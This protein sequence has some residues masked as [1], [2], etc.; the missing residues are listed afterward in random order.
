MKPR[1]A[2]DPASACSGPS[3][4][5]WA[6][7][8]TGCC[9]IFRQPTTFL[10]L[11]HY[12]PQPP[13][14]DDDA[15]GSAPHTDYGFL[16]ILRRRT[17]AA[18]WRCDARDGTWLPAPPIHGTWVVNVAD[19]L[20]RWTN[21][22]WQ[23]TPHRVRNVSGAERYSCPYFFDMAMDS[24][25]EVVPTCRATEISAGLVRYGDYL[26]ARLDRNYDY[27]KNSAARNDRASWRPPASPTPMPARSLC[28]TFRCRSRPVRSS[29]CWVRTAPASPRR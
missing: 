23:S 12:P 29:P 5:R 13:T 14:A 21:D 24:V 11:L 1:D 6:C 16:T 22:R 17:T 4:W 28:G 27:R 15:F 19:M 10:R 2:A 18:G 20:A 9:R 26:M 8:R 3:H 7:R 25:V